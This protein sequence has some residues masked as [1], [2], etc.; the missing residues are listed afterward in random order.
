[1]ARFTSTRPSRGC[2]SLACARP[3]QST[4]T[5]AGVDFY[6]APRQAPARRQAAEAEDAELRKPGE[7]EGDTGEGQGEASAPSE[8]TLVDK[9]LPPD[10]REAFK[11]D[12]VFIDSPVHAELLAEACYVFGIN[13]DP[14]V[15][16]RELLAHRFDQG[17]PNGT[18]AI[19]AGVSIV[20]GGGV[21]IRYP[22]D[23]ETEERLRVVYN[24]YRE[25]PKTHTRVVLPLPEN[26]TLPREQVDG[27]VRSTEHQY[28][29]GYLKE[30]GKAETAR[31]ATL[32]ALR[33]AGKLR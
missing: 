18:P 24:C 31:R 21:K 30:G 25:D 20:T 13:P 11:A 7:D 10:V 4:F 14:R 26:L 17:D 3:R 23:N 2:R 28:R 22:I 1:M 27:I 15:K 33:D 12:R 16:P 32:K 8:P 6:M 29:T 5:P 9:I 19:P